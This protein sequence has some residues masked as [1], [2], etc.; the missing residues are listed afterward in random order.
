MLSS[1]RAAALLVLTLL[2]AL[3]ACG[4]KPLYGRND[5]ADVV[6]EFSQISIAQPDNRGEQLLRNRLLDILTPKGAP[7]RPRYLLNYRV[8]DTVGAVF[9]T[10]NEEI[11]RSNVV[12]NV[13][14]T[15]HDYESGQPIFSV[16]AQSQASFNQSVNDYANLIAERDARD[17]AMRDAA[18]QIRIRLA[19]YFDRWRQ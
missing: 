10:R 9:V 19:N 15:L 13:S 3:A 16:S 6:P 11:T 18:E 7:E 14:T 5:G 4:F 1:S 12:V 2:P 17:R 8:T